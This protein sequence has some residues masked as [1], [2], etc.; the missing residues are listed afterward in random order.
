MESTQ[1]N[2]KTLDIIE[3]SFAIFYAAIGK[4]LEVLGHKGF[5]LIFMSILMVSFLSLLIIFARQHIYWKTKPLLTVFSMYCKLTVYVSMIFTMMKF[6]GVDIVWIVAMVSLIAY[7][8][9]SY[10]N[11][12]QSGQ[13]LNAYLYTVLISVANAAIFQ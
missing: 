9:L 8:I 7:G 13:I 2:L 12:K 5:A 1:K 4:L 10:F 6:Q 11:G 3:L